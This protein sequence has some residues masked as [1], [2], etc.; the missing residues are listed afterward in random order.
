MLLKERRD[1]ELKQICVEE[2]YFLGAMGVESID[3]E[4][5]SIEAALI[6]K[7]LYEESKGKVCNFFIPKRPPILIGYLRTHN[8]FKG[9]PRYFILDA[10]AGT[11]SKY[12]NKKDYPSTPLRIY[13]LHN[14]TSV[15]AIQMLNEQIAHP[16]YYFE[17]S[18]KMSKYKCFSLNKSSIMRWMEYIREGIIFSA[19][20]RHIESKLKSKKNKELFD[21]LEMIKSLK[22]KIVD[23]SEENDDLITRSL[24]QHN[25]PLIKDKSINE[26]NSAAKE[27]SM[28][29]PPQKFIPFSNNNIMPFIDNS[30]VTIKPISLE[31]ALKDENTSDNVNFKSFLLIQ[32]IGEGAFGKIFKVKKK[33]TGDIYAMKVL[34]K[35]FLEKQDQ[36]KYAIVEC[37]VLKL[38]NHPFIMKLH[39]SFQTS[40]YLYFILDYCGGNDLEVHLA[41]RGL[42][43]ESET[44]FFI[45]ELLLAIEYLHSKHVIYRDLKPG[46]ILLDDSGHIKLGDFGLAK[47]N[48]KDGDI[49]TTFC[50]SPVYIPPEV[51]AKKGSAK[52]ADVYQ[53]GA[54]MYE[55]LVGFPPFFADN[56]EGVYKNI[57]KGELEFPDFISNNSKNVL[58][59]MMEKDP[60]KRITL[61]ELKKDEFFRS[62]NWEK[63]YGKKVKP[64]FAKEDMNDSGD[65]ETQIVE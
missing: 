5:G 34:S 45:A 47:E 48:M 50:G 20:I 30:E 35:E 14:L 9:P 31:E 13:P 1:E 8:E 58:Q 23:I 19:F 29:P 54:V 57:E 32:K 63:L 26:Y 37:N 51:I 18:M 44:R 36:L 4:F 43:E 6:R 56:I 15:S 60:G 59:R 22:Q 42:F 2:N 16:R 52:S 24:T 28:S 40:K 10:I 55:M 33:D 53:M 27:H 25:P 12:K 62:I 38:V 65:E 46:N 3:S 39:W 17:Y 21:A 61:D 41:R 11:L 64:P 49:A 7:Q